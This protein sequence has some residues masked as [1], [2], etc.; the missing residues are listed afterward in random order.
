M[1][2]VRRGSEVAADAAEV[3]GLMA[4]DASMAELSK[5][6]AMAAARKIN[7][8]G[9]GDTAR[10]DSADPSQEGKI[11]PKD[12]KNLQELGTG[13]FSNIYLV[14]HRLNG[15]KYALKVIDKEEANRVRRR[16]PNVY[17]EIHMEK[18]ALTKLGGHP[19][20]IEMHA[21][22]QDFSCLYFLLEL[23]EG[24]ELWSALQVDGK[25]VGTH[26]SLAQFWMAE[27]LLS[28]EH[29]HSHGMVHRD[30][31]PEN[32]LLTGA[33]HLKVIDFGTSKDLVDAD[34]NGPEFVGT[35]QYMSPQAV[36]SQPQGREADLWAMACC[37]FQFLCGTTPFH[38]PSPYLCFLRI[39]SG[40]VLFPKVLGECAQDLVRSLLKVDPAERL[41]SDAT[42]GFLALKSHDYFQ[43]VGA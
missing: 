27:L 24:G 22:F 15:T 37:L 33:G 16:H 14:E 10:R 31:K 28:V 2:T 17:N 43:G 11:S 32:L 30:L 34:L 13:N 5:L 36:N 7:G 39:R 4:V 3:T 9:G 35:A 20:I 23:C 42:G 29:I 18:R 8:G 19:G 21:T 40:A 6:G 41:G 25:P 26:P 38:A 1:E 12:F